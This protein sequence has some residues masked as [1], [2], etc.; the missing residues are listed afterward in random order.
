MSLI[1]ITISSSY[2]EWMEDAF[3]KQMPADLWHAETGDG[4]WRAKILCLEHCPVIDKCLRH[5]LDHDEREGVWGGTSPADRSKIRK[6]GGKT[7]C[8]KNHAGK[9]TELVAR[10]NG[11]RRCKACDR[12][13]VAAKRAEKAAA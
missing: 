8:E 5:A 13:Y 4:T 12:A 2:V 7:N 6:Q 10:S 11:T 3:C 9:P 1:D